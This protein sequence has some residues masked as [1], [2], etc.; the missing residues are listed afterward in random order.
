MSPSQKGF[1]I[2]AD[3]APN[4]KAFLQK[5]WEIEY[6]VT[7]LLLL[8]W[9]IHVLFVSFDKL[10]FSINFVLHKIKSFSV[11]LGQFKRK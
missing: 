2:H 7:R 5:N 10:K 3:I 9:V 4:F 1:V 11:K 8:P 6:Y